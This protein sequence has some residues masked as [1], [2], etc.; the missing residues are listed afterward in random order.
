[1]RV[2]ALAQ[3]DRVLVLAQFD[4]VLA[5]VQLTGMRVTVCC[6]LTVLYAA[7]NMLYAVK[8]RVCAVVGGAVKPWLSAF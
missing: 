1:M 2:L 3:F 4:G 7:C 5:L 8:Q 6:S